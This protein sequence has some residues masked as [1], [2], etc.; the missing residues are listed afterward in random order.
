MCAPDYALWAHLRFY[1]EYLRKPGPVHTALWK[2]MKRAMTRRRKILDTRYQQLI[3]CWHI[4]PKQGTPTLMTSAAAYSHFGKAMQGLWIPRNCVLRIPLWCSRVFLTAQGRPYF[5]RALSKACVLTVGD[6]ISPSGDIHAHLL[7]KV[8]RSFRDLY[9]RQLTLMACAIKNGAGV[10]IPGRTSL[11][12]ESWPMRELSAG[13]AALAEPE[14]RQALG[15]S[16]ALA[17]LRLPTGLQDFVRQALWR[18]LEVSVRMLLCR[19]A[20]TAVCALCG[21]REDHHHALKSCPFLERGIALAR[22][23]WSL[24]FNKHALVQPSRI[25]RDLAQLSLSTHVRLFMFGGSF[26]TLQTSL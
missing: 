8:A 20:P 7:A 16:E 12:P 18:K 4:K 14:G 1:V 10:H 3:I 13:C 2:E 21:D 17:K 11:E 15:V 23:S 24:R 9:E 22:V 25:C 6:I 26:R 19:Q 5:C